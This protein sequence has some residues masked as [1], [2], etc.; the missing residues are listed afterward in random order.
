MPETDDYHRAEIFSTWVKRLGVAPMRL[1]FV[2]KQII[3]HRSHNHHQL[4][5][6]QLQ[7]MI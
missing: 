4:H 7:N 1:A 2:N 6:A 5:S 3:Q